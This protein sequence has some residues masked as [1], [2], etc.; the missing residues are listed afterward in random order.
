MDGIRDHVMNVDVCLLACD[1]N[2]ILGFASARIFSKFSLCY[3]HGI[4]VKNTEQQR[5][6]G[7]KLLEFLMQY[8]SKLGRVALCT[9][10]VMASDSAAI[11]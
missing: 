4:A 7:T 6:I 2:N 11:C 10:P 1:D 8:Y 9:P 5:G 3:L